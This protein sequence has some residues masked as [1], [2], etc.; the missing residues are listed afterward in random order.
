MNWIAAAGWPVI[1]VTEIL[2]MPKAFCQ[3]ENTNS[4]FR[5][6]TNTEIL[7]LLAKFPVVWLILILGLAFVCL[8]SCLDYVYCGAVCAAMWLSFIGAGLAEFGL[9]ARGRRA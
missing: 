3:A 2:S 5:P 9:Q 1:K 6:S 7:I 4:A 8:N